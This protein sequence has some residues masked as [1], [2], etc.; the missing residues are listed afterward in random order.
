MRLSELL[1]QTLREAPAEAEAI[2][3]K[4][5]LRAGL[6]RQHAAGIYS[7][8]PLG[9]RVPRKAD[10]IAREHM[11]RIESRIADLIDRLPPKS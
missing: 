10:A 8:L 6:V 11:L 3:H 1:V 9:L 5:M 7:W 4:L 2:S